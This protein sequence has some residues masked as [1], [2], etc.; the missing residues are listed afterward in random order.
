MDRDCFA[1]FLQKMDLVFDSNISIYLEGGRF[2]LLQ[3]I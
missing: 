1:F 3:M 2:I